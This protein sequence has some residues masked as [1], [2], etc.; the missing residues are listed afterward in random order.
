MRLN[1]RGMCLSETLSVRPNYRWQTQLELH[2]PFKQRS[3]A[4]TVRSNA[5]QAGR[6]YQ[7]SLT[8]HGLQSATSIESYA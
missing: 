7:T 6:F 3:G 5:K 4:S 1:V 2:P 8:S